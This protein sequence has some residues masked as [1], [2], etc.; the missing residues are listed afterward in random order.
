MKVLL[1]WLARRYPN[2]R[3]LV[4]RWHEWTTLEV[5]APT[6]NPIVPGVSELTDDSPPSRKT[7]QSSL[8]AELLSWIFVIIL[9][10]ALPLLIIIVFIRYIF[11]MLLQKLRK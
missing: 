6:E 1:P 7:N 10:I 9:F 8:P 5:E 2:I 11:R 4:Y 3:E